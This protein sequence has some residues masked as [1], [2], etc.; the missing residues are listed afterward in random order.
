MRKICINLVKNIRINQQL[1]V[2]NQNTPQILAKKNSFIY[3]PCYFYFSNAQQC[4]HEHKTC[5]HENSH[6]QF[7]QGQQKKQQRDQDPTCNNCQAKNFKKNKF[8]CGTCKTLLE[9]ERKLYKTD[10]F[11]LFGMKKSFEVDKQF[12]EQQ[13]KEM[14]QNFHPDRYYA[15]NNGEQVKDS[16]SYSAYVIQAYETLKN[17]YDRAEY[18]ISLM[19][20][21]QTNEEDIQIND[22][23]FLEN[24]MDLREKIMECSEPEKLIKIKEQ[25]EKD[26]Q[27][28]LSSLSQLFKENNY[29][30][31]LQQLKILKYHIS[32][33]ELINKKEEHFIFSK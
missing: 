14:I 11:D 15:I 31:C 4:N 26:K 25:T 19:S 9:P 2:K 10:F 20:D 18:F 27:Q 23:E 28:T 5:T 7:I 6:D 30:E 8:I 24:L 17:D 32:T 16:E 12:L 33:L 3:Q 22:F 21:I 13:Y 1:C 29:E